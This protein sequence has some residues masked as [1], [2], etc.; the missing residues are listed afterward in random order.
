MIECVD[1]GEKKKVAEACSEPDKT[2]DD[3]VNQ[4]SS[5]LQ[6]VRSRDWFNIYRRLI[7]LFA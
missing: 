5:L 1:Q 6:E 4:D 7:V 2:H 3:E